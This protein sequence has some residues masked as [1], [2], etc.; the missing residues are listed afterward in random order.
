MN[1]KLKTAAL[2]LGALLFVP[3]VSALADSS[4]S[5]MLAD[6][7]RRHSR[8][9]SEGE[10]EKL[11]GHDESTD[12]E[13]PAQGRRRTDSSRRQSDG[14]WKFSVGAEAFYGLALDDIYDGEDEDDFGAEKI[15]VY[16]VNV[17]LSMKGTGTLAPEFFALFGAGMGEA[18]ESYSY[19]EYFSG[20]YEYDLFEM[21]AMIGANLRW[22]ITDSFSVFGG[23]QV[24]IVSQ[25]VEIEDKWTEEDYWDGESYSDSEKFKFDDD[26]IGLRCG[27]GVGAEWN[28]TENHALRVG[29]DYIYSTA[30]PSYKEEEWGGETYKFKLE[31]QSYVVFSIGYQYTF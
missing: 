23:G 25:K 24:G 27:L 12:W 13:R 14:Y 15:D 20:K 18:D 28:I 5:Q 21:H 30:R 17:R 16:G 29:A 1:T 9:L 8:S 19:D 6:F 7:E 3:A 2:S 11:I 26:T 31:R 4:Y 10:R 22:N